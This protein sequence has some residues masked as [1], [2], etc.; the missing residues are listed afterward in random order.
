MNLKQ[1]WDRLRVRPWTLAVLFLG[2]AGRS[3]LRTVGDGSLH[4]DEWT[5]DLRWKR[6][7]P[8]GAM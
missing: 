6:E 4:G 2:S 3:S 8:L 7:H 5:S 1:G